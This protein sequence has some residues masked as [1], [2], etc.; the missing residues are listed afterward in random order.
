MITRRADLG[1]ALSLLFLF[2]IAVEST[3]AQ[4][5]SKP[6]SD[7]EVQKAAEKKALVLLD[8]VMAAAMTMN[9]A[10]NRIYI[11]SR[12]ADLLWTR[13]EKRARSLFQDATASLV[14]LINSRDGNESRHSVA[15]NVRSSLRQ[16]MLRLV[17]SYDPELALDFLRAT[18]RPRLPDETIHDLSNEELQ[19][20]QSLAAQ[21]SARDPKRA[22]QIAE[23]SLKNG[24]TYGLVNL[25]AKLRETDDE[26]ATKFANILIAKLRS[27][28][29]T[30]NQQ[31]GSI[32]LGLLRMAIQSPSP[33][34]SGNQARPSDKKV[35]LL[36]EY[37]IRE[38]V[39]IVVTTALRTS[40]GNRISGEYEN[41][42]NF[43]SQLRFMRV[44]VE[45]YAPSRSSALKA[46][47]ADFDK[48]MDEHN[49]MR[50]E[51]FDLLQDNIDAALD[52]IDK[53]QP[54]RRDSLY[55][56]AGAKV[57]REGDVERGRQIMNEISDPEFRN[58]ALTNIDRHLTKLASSEGKFGDAQ[59]LLSRISKNEDRVMAMA[60][61]ATTM[62]EKGDKKAALE[63]L[64]SAWGLIAGRIESVAQIGA[65]LEV[66]RAYISL[67]TG[68]SF[69][70][71]GQLIDQFNEVIAALIVIDRFQHK[72]FVRDGEFVLQ[73]R[74]SLINGM[75]SRFVDE[76]SHL[77]RADFDRAR[78]AADR[79][80]HPETRTLARLL[81]AQG[82]LSNQQK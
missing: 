80:Q 7:E 6:K 1:T 5:A 15:F 34:P 78:V 32:A 3:S 29:L 31:A 27:E 13:D 82:I 46:K 9:L 60:Q 10:E 76:L 79:F 67:D 57:L 74:F 48:T 37:S 43:I 68:A 4:E 55:Y 19:L 61:L 18:R 59:R 52:F 72:M 65:Q 22:L 81:V 44:E 56:E 75:Y 47:I 14:A 39:D 16:H 45:K 41:A 23:Q 26:A 24:V 36:D 50:G 40:P 25:L 58:M 28:N 69:D 70:I 62:A 33:S 53:A 30:S 73:R 63:M 54:D 2:A 20:E 38:L 17:S 66:A 35:R 21:I 77:S 71:M 51:F 12:V 42:R 64:A 11:Q 8:D 49:R